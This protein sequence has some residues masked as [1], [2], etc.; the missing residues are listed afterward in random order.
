MSNLKKQNV[1][2]FEPVTSKMDKRCLP[3]MQLLQKN[4]T[5]GMRSIR[6]TVKYWTIASWLSH[7]L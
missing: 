4:V 7:Y 6:Y 5:S 2:G 1:G 3:Q